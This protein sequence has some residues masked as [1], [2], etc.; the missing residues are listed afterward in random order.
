MLPRMLTLILV[1]AVTF[2]LVSAGA[3]PNL[4]INP[5]EHNFGDVQYGKQASTRFTVRNVGGQPLVIRRVRTSCGCTKAD[6]SSGELLPKESTE[7]TVTF[8]SSG[9]KAGKNIKT[10][11]LESNDQHNPVTEVSI[12]A[13][14]VKEVVVEPSR[15]VTR[16]TG[17]RERVGFPLTVRNRSASTVTLAFSGIQGSLEKAVLTPQKVTVAPGNESRFTITL[18][19][20][21]RDNRKYFNGRFIL[22]TDH[23]GE[24][25]IGL[26]YF[27]KVDKAR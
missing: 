25:W 9:L 14:V 6:L 3:S 21:G 10:V 7:L 11:F 23:P 12:F 17:Y 5:K 26:P 24:K 20:T 13:N 15:L 27:I 4:D 2:P 1:T 8:D 16:L 22:E 19:L 18:E